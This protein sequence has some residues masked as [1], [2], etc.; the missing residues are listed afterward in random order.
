MLTRY[1][2]QLK[3]AQGAHRSGA[4]PRHHHARHA[5]G[6]NGVHLG[7]Y[8]PLRQETA[9]S[10]RKERRPREGADDG[11]EPAASPA[12]CVFNLAALSQLTPSSASERRERRHPKPSITERASP[13]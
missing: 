7:A 13:P 10:S 5:A 1:K 12:D 4:S 9:S 6:R 11:V 8:R 3:H 2:G